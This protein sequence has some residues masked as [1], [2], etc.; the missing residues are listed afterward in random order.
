MYKKYA[1]MG[2]IMFENR[3]FIANH[4]SFEMVIFLLKFKTSDPITLMLY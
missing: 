4:I 2:N 1:K 3:I